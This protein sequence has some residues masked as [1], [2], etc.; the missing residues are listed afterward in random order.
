MRD[1]LNALLHRRWLIFF[2]TLLLW[3]VALIGFRSARTGSDYFL[4]LLWNLFLA[5]IPLLVSRLL[6]IAHH[7]GSADSAQ[8]FLVA[9]W[10]L[11][12]P[13]APYIFT[14]FVHLHES[15]TLLYWYDAVLLLSCA[16]TGLLL[17]YS[18]LIDV[19]AISAAR[20]GHKLGWGVAIVAL[21][22][23]GY[24]VYLG[25]VQRWNSW[26]IVTN[27]LGLMN[28]IANVLLNPVDHFHVYALSG[29]MSAALLL[30]Y[31]ALRIFIGQSVIINPPI[32]SA[33]HQPD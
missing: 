4:F 3:C 17:G 10:L 5:C 20:F 19:H 14:D 22:L 16:G 29:L 8:L 7:R 18:S 6:R 25:R 33:A 9:V 23:S 11:F 30:G 27:P 24:G 2:S 15:S 12:L 28:N 1:K 26:D 32:I 21:L 13:N 31:A